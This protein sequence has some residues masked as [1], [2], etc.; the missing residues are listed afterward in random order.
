M[1]KRWGK[2][3]VIKIARVTLWCNSRDALKRGCPLSHDKRLCMV[4]FQCAGSPEIDKSNPHG[5]THQ[6]DEVVFIDEGVS[7]MCFDVES[8]FLDYA[9][10]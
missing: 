7:V 6:F 9:I 1:K 8:N 4:A 5:L 3:G 2:S 10:A